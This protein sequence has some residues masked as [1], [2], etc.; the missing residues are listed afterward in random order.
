MSG[1]ETCASCHHF[2]NE[3]AQVE[4]GLPGLRALGSAHGSVRGSDGLCEHHQRYV[5]ASSYCE[6][7]QVRAA[8][9]RRLTEN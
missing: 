6:A 7:H 1:P 2:R 4:A 8:S 3:P 9:R 5:R